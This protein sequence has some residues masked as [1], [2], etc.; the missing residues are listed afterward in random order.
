MSH[1]SSQSIGMM[2]KVV[3]FNVMNSGQFTFLLNHPSFLSH[4][5]SFT[6]LRQIIGAGATMPTQKHRRLGSIPSLC[7]QASAK[8]VHHLWRQRMEFP[9]N[10]R[11]I[12]SHC[13]HLPAE[14]LQ[15]RRCGR[16]ANG[17]S[18]RVCGILAGPIENRSHCSADQYKSTASVAYPQCGDCKMPSVDLWRIVS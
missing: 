4:S 12:E 1:H 3:Q 11:S 15:K 5:Q 7:G 18:A 8:S 13:Q 2:T 16:F 9:W 17:Q 14:W 10:K 6:S